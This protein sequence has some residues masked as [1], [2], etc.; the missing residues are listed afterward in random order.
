MVLLSESS[1]I[2][3]WLL[4]N[5]SLQPDLVLRSEPLASK[6]TLTKSPKPV[7]LSVLV[8]CSHAKLLILPFSLSPER[9]AS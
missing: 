8:L 4:R 1:F 5:T 7:L 9:H 6:E 3:H 2:C